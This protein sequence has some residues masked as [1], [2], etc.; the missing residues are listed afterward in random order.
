MEDYELKDAILRFLSENPS[1]S[2]IATEIRKALNIRLRDHRLIEDS[3]KEM[4]ADRYIDKIIPNEYSITSKGMEFIDNEGGYTS[5]H[6]EEEKTKEKERAEE[7]RQREIA[8]EKLQRER[9]SEVR[10]K[11]DEKRAIQT[12]ERSKRAESRERIFMWIAIA[13]FL[14]LVGSWIYTIWFK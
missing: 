4:V 6:V 2:F 5:Q 13:E 1:E 14:L 7:K 12:D 8:E 11:R 3:L 9:D 10:A